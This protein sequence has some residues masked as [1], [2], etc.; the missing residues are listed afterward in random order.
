VS[1]IALSPEAV[2]RPATHGVFRDDGPFARLVGRALGRRLPVPPFALAAAGAIPLFVAIAATGDG[3]SNALAGIVVAWFVALAGC[4][5]GRLD[6]TRLRWMGTPFV[7]AGEYAGLIWIGSL[8]GAS[9]VPAVFALLTVVAYRHYDLVYRLRIR[10][11]VPPAWVG[12][13]A[14]GWDGRLVLA[15]LLLVVDALPAGLYVAAGLLA[16]VL[17]GETVAGWRAFLGRQGSGDVISY[18]DEEDE[19]Q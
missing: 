8:A 3:A 16:V 1:A 2:A 10:R 11:E 4:S 18:E 5:T 15:Y 13:V 12:V 9:S 6:H 19:G 7:R 14:G 17:I